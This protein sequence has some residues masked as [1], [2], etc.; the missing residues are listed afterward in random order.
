MAVDYAEARPPYPQRIFDTLQAAEVIGPGLR[1]LE[2]GAGAGLATKELASRGCEVVALEPGTQLIALLRD[3]VPGV[4]VLATRLEDAHLPD[5][6]FDSVVAATSMHWVDLAVALP[7]VHAALR[8]GGCLAVWRTIFGDEDAE[9]E[10]RARVSQIVSQREGND[11]ASR[12]HRPTMEELTAGDWF[13][14]ERTEHWRWSIELSTDRI[15]RLFATFSN[16]SP[17]EV[18]AATQAADDLGGSVT[19][20]YRSVLHLLRRRSH[21]SG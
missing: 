19:E 20:R 16:W 1:V 18:V 8:P 5:Q 7:K 15:R 3:A 10:F 9:T 2:I 4:E 21:V 11:D 17:A 13:E 14:P 12:E 6:T